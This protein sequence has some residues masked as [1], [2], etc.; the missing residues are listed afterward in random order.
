MPHGCVFLNIEITNQVDVVFTNSTFLG[1]GFFDGI[2]IERVNLAADYSLVNCTVKHRPN[3][4]QI[5]TQAIERIVLSE[6]LD[7]NIF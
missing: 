7:F 4:S 3:C 1:F 6:V 5:K 2:F